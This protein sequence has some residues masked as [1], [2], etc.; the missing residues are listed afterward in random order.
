MQSQL[1]ITVLGGNRMVH[2]NQLGAVGKRPFDLQLVNHARDPGHDLVAAQQLASQVHEFGDASAF[3]YEF[4][5]LRCD[6]SNGFGIIQA[7]SAR[8]SLLGHTS[9]VVQEQLIYFSRRKVHSRYFTIFVPR[10]YRP[11]VAEGKPGTGA[12]HGK[13]LRH[14]HPR[15]EPARRS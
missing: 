13:L 8:Q 15:S 11:T 2:R 14:A 3:A 9:R 7:E 1:K 10:D 6:Q 4:E 5:Q 12:T